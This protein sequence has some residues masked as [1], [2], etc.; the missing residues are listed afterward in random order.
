MSF[1]LV[2]IFESLKECSMTRRHAAGEVKVCGYIFRPI[3]HN[4]IQKLLT[5]YHNSSKVH[6]EH[7]CLVLITTFD[8]LLFV[9]SKVFY[10]S[11]VSI[12]TQFYIFNLVFQCHGQ[13]NT[14]RISVKKYYQ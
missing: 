9:N 13:N 14:K 1:Y 12:L 11:S 4:F 3:F 6:A 10:K 5:L 2:G 8:V 7:Y